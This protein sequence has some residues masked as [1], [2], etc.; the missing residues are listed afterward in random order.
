MKIKKILFIIGIILLMLNAP[1]IFLSL[2]NSSS[3]NETSTKLNNDI[4]LNDV[5]VKQ[6]IVRRANESDEEYVFRITKIIHEGIVDYWR[7]EGIVK[8]NLRVPI[9]ENYLLYLASFIKPDIYRKYEFADYNKAIERGVGQCSQQ[10]IIVTGILNDNGID[11]EII[12]LSGHFVLRA[13][14]KENTWYVV[15]PDFGVVIPHDIFEIE[16]NPDLI[17]PYYGDIESKLNASEGLSSRMVALYGHYGNVIYKNGV[18]GYFGQKL[19]YFEYL[20]YIAIWVIPLIM[21]MPYS[22]TVLKRRAKRE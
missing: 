4:T 12:A 18:I 11:A 17:R 22:L 9:W 1:G 16:A 5:E 10:A 21:F 2:R 3:N 6:Q 7:D 20:S 15:D 14:V 19:Y 13:K 8:Y